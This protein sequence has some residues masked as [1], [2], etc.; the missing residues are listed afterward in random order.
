MRQPVSRRG[1]PK[2]N[3][4]PAITQNLNFC[5][6][7]KGRGV[8]ALRGVGCHPL[9][10][11]KCMDR[12]ALFNAGVALGRAS[13]LGVRRDAHGCEEIKKA[14]G[15][16]RSCEMASEAEAL[17]TVGDYVT[18]P[19]VNCHINAIQAQVHYPDQH[20][21]DAGVN[22]GCAYEIAWGKH[23]QD[24][25][26]VMQQLKAAQQHLLALELEDEPEI[27]RSVDEVLGSISQLAAPA[28]AA[29]LP[30]HKA[31]IQHLSESVGQLVQ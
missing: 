30:D 2:F 3:G 29:N 31:M 4:A 12:N 1:I 22:M 25:R 26:R 13:I 24:V 20:A 11:G 19:V 27:A 16:L 21:F 5:I 23:V 17:E 28:G 8:D 9:S 6:I 15:H 18:A 7:V 14:A 10:L